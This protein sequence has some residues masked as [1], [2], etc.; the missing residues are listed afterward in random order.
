MEL[1]SQAQIKHWFP[2]RRPDAHKGNFGRVLIV[3]GSQRMCGA[4]LLCAH[5]ALTA[6]AGLVYW[7]LPAAMQPAFAAAMPEVITI[8]L[9]QTSRGELDASAWEQ[10]PEICQTCHP[11][12]V[13]LGPGM[14]ESPLLPLLLANLA[15]PLLVDADAL[16]ALARQ[17]GWQIAWPSERP[18]IFTPHP[19][20]M[21]R[22]LNTSLATDP[23]VRQAQAQTLATQTRG[24][25]VLKGP[26]TLV[27]AMEQQT[28]SL[29]QNTT[30]NAA[31]AKGGSGDVLS[32]VIAGLWAQ[33]GSAEGFSVRTALHAAVCG[34][35]L[36][37]LAGD[38]AARQK[39]SYSVLAR[40]LIAALPEAFKQVEAA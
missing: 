20:E 31:L 16:N 13:V 25:C 10:F 3:A 27:A 2:I 17:P 19:G 26:A 23:A 4:G 8:P 35:Y 39:G 24:V 29:F 15:M 12:L 37:G 38:L 33:L 32:G 36:H 30:G 34:V 1:L 6:G 21:A 14:G 7:A 11:S 40:D 5:G 9:P 18:C 22:L 28:R